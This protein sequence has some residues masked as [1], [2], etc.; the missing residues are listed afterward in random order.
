LRSLN[1]DLT[2][3]FNKSYSYSIQDN[4]TVENIYGVVATLGKPNNFYINCLSE[5]LKKKVL[6]EASSK[7]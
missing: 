1:G 2:D 5:E 6:D 4:D 3:V 7:N